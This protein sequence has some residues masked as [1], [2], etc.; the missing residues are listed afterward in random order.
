MQIQVIIQVLLR[1]TPPSDNYNS[2]YESSS[3]W[4]DRHLSIRKVSVS[5]LPKYNRLLLVPSSCFYSTCQWRIVSKLPTYMLC[6]FPIIVPNGQSSRLLK[7]NE[8]ISLNCFSFIELCRRMCGNSV[9]N[10][11]FAILLLLTI[12]KLNP[13]CLYLLGLIKTLVEQYIIM[14]RSNI[15]F[16]KNHSTMSG[17]FFYC[18][19]FGILFPLVKSVILWYNE[20]HVFWSSSLIFGNTP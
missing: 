8:T 15:W 4:L 18:I 11:I 17:L 12:Y 6:S 7:V 13:M 19:S 2:P 14:F 20:K 5:F 9:S 16:K 1:I 10:W 3:I